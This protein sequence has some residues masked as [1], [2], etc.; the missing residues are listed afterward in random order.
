MR[1]VASYNPDVVTDVIR[2]AIEAKG[3]GAAA[4][5]ARCLKVAPGTVT[6]YVKGEIQPDVDRWEAIEKC[7]GLDLGLLARE[8]G[9]RS[10]P[11]D[12]LAELREQVRRLQQTVDRLLGTT[13]DGTEATP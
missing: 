2:Q 5:L 10:V 4:D 7:L 11:M 8:S 3:R 1:T 6:K 12:E 13:G 9:Y